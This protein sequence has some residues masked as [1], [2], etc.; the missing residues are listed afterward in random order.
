MLSSSGVTREFWAEAM[1]T[2]AYL[3][4]RCPSTAI[5][6]KTPLEAW[7]GFKLD[8]SNLRTFGCAA[9]AHHKDTHLLKNI[10]SISV[11]STKIETLYVATQNNF[12]FQS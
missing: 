9:Y 10:F 12:N 2:A 6:L 11:C 5:G 1:H 8:L 4:N 3:V 7:T